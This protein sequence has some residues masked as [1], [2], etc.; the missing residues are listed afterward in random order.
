METSIKESKVNYKEIVREVLKELEGPLT[1]QDI[2]NIVVPSPTHQRLF[3]MAIG[4]DEG[5]DVA[6]I[7]IAVSI[8]ANNKV[9]IEKNNT[10]LNLKDVLLERGVPY[11]DIVH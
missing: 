2:E 9:K 7:M 6:Q 1:Y 11:S 5:K 4:T 3:L 10:D 8:T